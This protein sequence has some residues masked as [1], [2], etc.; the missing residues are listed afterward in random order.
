MQ[1]R[2]LYVYFVNLLICSVIFLT[3]SNLFLT[4][5]ES[6]AYVHGLRV[7]YLIP[8]LYASDLP[9]LLLIVIWVIEEVW[10][11]KNREVRLPSKK[12]N[13]LL[14]CLAALVTRQIW[15]P[16]PVVSIWY[17]A[18]VLT[19]YLFGYLSLYHKQVFKP[20]L[21][22]WA[23][24]ITMLFQ[25]SL[26]ILQYQLQR[27]VFPSY[28]YLGETR[29]DAS[30]GIQLAQID[31]TYRISPYGTTPH[32]NIL[33][34]VLVIYLLVFYLLTQQDDSTV[35]LSR[36]DDSDNLLV[37]IRNLL[38]WSLS[39]ITLYLTQSISAWISLGFAIV[40]IFFW[41]VF[42]NHIKRKYLQLILYL[43]L[44][45]YLLVH[46]L[47]PNVLKLIHSLTI[48]NFLDQTSFS[49]RI[50]F[51]EV[52]WKM[53]LSNPT[54]GVGLNSFTAKIEDFSSSMSIIWPDA[55]RFLQPAHHVGLLL[56]AETG[57][58]GILTLIT[59]TVV[60]SDAITKAFQKDSLRHNKIELEDS[61]LHQ[62]KSDN[63]GSEINSSRSLNFHRVLFLLVFLPLISLDHYILT[64]QIG[65]LILLLPGYFSLRSR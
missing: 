44:H 27:S 59:G 46:L 15:S 63:L 22:K 62:V 58:L 17:F 48:G 4:L 45:L 19:L 56:L 49:K 39:L 6:S 36:A 26:G 16:T 29:L 28:S 31:D 9:I 65:L 10:R 23:V 20:K 40:F 24:V 51:N 53:F 25:S 11:G 47:S 14:I 57:V 33:G 5:S 54:F 60:M 13:L 3:P 35:K 30:V 12:T 2:Q 32:P 7:D 42:L 61:N 37:T 21:L 64:Q 18:K 38:V 50:F 43:T 52:A 8:K 41:K 1:L 34:G 55:I